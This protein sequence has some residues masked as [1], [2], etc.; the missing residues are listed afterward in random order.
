MNNPVRQTFQRSLERL[1]FKT[2]ASLPPAKTC[3][4]L[5]A[6]Q[7]IGQP[8]TYSGIAGQA[9]PKLFHTYFRIDDELM[10][11]SGL[12]LCYYLLSK[13]FDYAFR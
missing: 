10:I 7:A 13:R 1:P 11:D 5:A 9:S 12:N 8:A 2:S 6:V 4:K 3:W